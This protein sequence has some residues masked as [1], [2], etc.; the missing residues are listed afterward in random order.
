M[1]E[2]QAILDPFPSQEATKVATAKGLSPGQIS[3]MM[4]AAAARAGMGEE[5]SRDSGLVR[6]AQE[7]SAEGAELP[8]LMAG[9]RYYANKRGRQ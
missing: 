8:A 7:L 5:Y 1:T 6:M 4:K 3:R 9:S 2:H